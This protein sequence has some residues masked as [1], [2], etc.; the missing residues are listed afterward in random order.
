MWEELLERVQHNSSTTRYLTMFCEA[1]WSKQDSVNLLQ[2]LFSV[3][4]YPAL[5]WLLLIL[6]EDDYAFVTKCNKKYER[7]E[8]SSLATAVTISCSVQVDIS[9][10]DLRKALAIVAYRKRWE[11]LLEWMNVVSTWFQ[12]LSATWRCSVALGSCNTNSEI[13]QKTLFTIVG[14]SFID[15]ATSILLIM[16]SVINHV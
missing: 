8:S 4:H 9:V 13:S 14:S 15:H 3:Y 5:L 16:G 11:E 10:L 12:S 6:N 1:S 7:G 2:Y